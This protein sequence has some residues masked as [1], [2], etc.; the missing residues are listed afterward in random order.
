[1]SPEG[2]LKAVQSSCSGSFAGQKCIERVEQLYLSHPID[3]EE[4]VVYTPL[5][6]TLTVGR[7]LLLGAHYAQGIFCSGNVVSS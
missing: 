5:Q 4:K 6:H 3:K 7:V 2:A 1:M